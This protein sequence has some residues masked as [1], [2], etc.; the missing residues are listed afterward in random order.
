MRYYFV[1]ITTA[2]EKQARM[3][4]QEL[5]RSRLAACVNIL[6]AMKSIYW[7]KGKIEKAR[8][9]VLIAKTTRSR[10]A[11]LIRKVKI[12]HSYEC[13]CIAALPIVAG[14]KNYINWIAAETAAGKRT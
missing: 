5:V 6:P 3:I 8:E 13:P 11:A 10:I 9:A 7:W 14:N 2:N 1:Y 4:G 12:L